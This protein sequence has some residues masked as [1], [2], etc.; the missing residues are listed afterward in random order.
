MA[1]S[2]GKTH[3]PYSPT[4]NL[5]GRVGDTTLVTCR[6]Q[7]LD[8]KAYSRNELIT[9]WWTISHIRG[10]HLQNLNMYGQNCRNS[11]HQHRLQHL[12]TAGVIV[13]KWKS[14]TQIHSCC[15]VC[16]QE[17]FKIMHG[18]A[19]PK[20]VQCLHILAWAQYTMCSMLGCMQYIL[21]CHVGGRNHINFHANVHDAVLHG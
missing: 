14:S 9:I 19:E 21:P 10:Y 15:T 12:V 8:V 16:Q 13:Q 7:S 3:L 18:H 20:D 11:V 17:G 6:K 1:C 4:K 2:N 5:L